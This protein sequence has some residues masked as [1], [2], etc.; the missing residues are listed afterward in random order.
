MLDRYLFGMGPGR[1][2]VEVG[3]DMIRVRG[4]TNFRLDIPRASVRS[5]ARSQFPTKGT[6]GVHEI[7]GHWLV[8][9]SADGLVEL[10]I[11]PPL[12]VGRSLS[13]AFTK[14]RVDSLI[15]SLADPDGFIAA[16]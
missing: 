12:P 11:D 6:I 9:G 15:V 1:A 16:V 14:G 10:V 2:G 4:L 13:T 5:V 8:N 7:D 3:P